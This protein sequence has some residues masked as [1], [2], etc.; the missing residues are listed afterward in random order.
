MQTE[1]NALDHHYAQLI[2]QMRGL[3]SCLDSEVPQMFTEVLDSVERLFSFESRL[4]DTYCFPASR[5]HVEQHARVL[6]GL[7]RTHS[8][9]MRGELRHGRHAGTHLLMN[10]FE[11]HNGTLD[12]CLMVWL[13][14]VQAKRTMP[15]ITRGALPPEIM[16]DLNNKA[17]A[18]RRPLR[19]TDQS[20]AAS[21]SGQNSQGPGE[22]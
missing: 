6:A 15:A 19:P 8:Q 2:L 14:S 13:E 22:Q 12:A 10:W 21:I 20:N 9:V 11:L 18:R 4:M 5:C 3:G 1:L 17:S 7:H 16:R